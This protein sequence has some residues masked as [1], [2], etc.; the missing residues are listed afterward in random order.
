MAVERIVSGKASKEDLSLD[1][2]LRPRTLDEFIGQDRVK[3]NLIIAIKASKARGEPLDHTLFHGPPGLGKTTLAHIIANEMGTSIKVTSGPAIE[4]PGELASILSNLK[5][6]DILF[7][8]EIHRLGKAV[9]EKLYPAMEDFALDIVV[10]KGAGARSIRLKLP[11]FT[12]I[13]ATTRFALLSPPLRDRFGA[14]F[15]LGY[16]D[17][18]S[19]KAIIRRSAKALKVEIEEGAVEEIARRSRGTPRV[20]NRLLKRLRDY[21]IVKG[22]GRITERVALEALKSLEIDS[23]GLDEMDLK[24]LR[25]LIFKFDGG[26]VGIET[27]AAALGEDADT[28]MDIY[29]PYLL[30]LGFIDRTPRGRLATRLA[31]EHLGI[32]YPG[33]TQPTL[34]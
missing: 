5:Y 20:A 21:A 24:L 27:L 26:P 6:G 28:I 34:F 29:E 31:Y 16:Y 11:P 9:E 33:A 13:G 15:H 3:E 30:Q 32:P 23:L 8:D 2:T 12:L 17:I 7:I 19:M 22:D 14:V 18:N 1:I 10:G 25:T 4:K